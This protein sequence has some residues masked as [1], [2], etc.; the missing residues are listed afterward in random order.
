LLR[1]ARG[2]EVRL[3]AR[4]GE[5]RDRIATVVIDPQAGY[6]AAIRAALP[7]AQLAVDHFH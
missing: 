4:S 1:V 6:A 2:R 7:N 3:A 5:F